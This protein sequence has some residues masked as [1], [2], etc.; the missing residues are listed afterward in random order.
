MQNKVEHFK[1]VIFVYMTPQGLRMVSV[2]QKP[3]KH[4]FPK[5]KIREKRIFWKNR[6]LPGGL[7]G[8]AI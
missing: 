1:I 4:D 6:N 5:L 8:E 3:H 7:L 2:G